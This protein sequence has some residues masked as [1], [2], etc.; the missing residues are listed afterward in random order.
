MTILFLGSF[1]PLK[2]QLAQ[3]EPLAGVAL[4]VQLLQ[5]VDFQDFVWKRN[6][7]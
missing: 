7:D 4:E 2:P 3:S 6:Y 5:T 1:L